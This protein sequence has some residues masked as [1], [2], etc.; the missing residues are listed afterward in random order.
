MRRSNKSRQLC[1]SSQPSSSP[2]A[3]QGKKSPEEL[4]ALALADTKLAYAVDL[5]KEHGSTFPPELHFISS[6][7]SKS[8]D[9][10]ESAVRAAHAFDSPE[11]LTQFIAEMKIK[12]AELSATAAVLIAPKAGIAFPQVSS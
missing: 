2:P 1:H 12:A 9:S 4:A 11:V 7:S 6:S 3:V 5:I 8:G 10:A